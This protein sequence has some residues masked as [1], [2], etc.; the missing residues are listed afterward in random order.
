MLRI[1]RLRSHDQHVY[2]L[3]WR[4]MGFLRSKSRDVCLITQ[5]QNLKRRPPCATGCLGYSLHRVQGLSS[6]QITIDDDL[7]S[8]AQRRSYL[9]LYGCP[10]SRRQKN[11]ALRLAS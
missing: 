2:A 5:A 1:L 6:G 3:I 4:S 10:R 8:L 11:I 9:F 7:I